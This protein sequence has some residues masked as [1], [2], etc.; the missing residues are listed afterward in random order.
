MGDRFLDYTN[1]K[2]ENDAMRETLKSSLQQRANR[3]YSRDEVGDERG[4]FRLQLSRM[5]RETSQAYGQSDNLVS[6]KQ[7]CDNIRAISDKLS[8]QFGKMLKDQRLR[9]GTSQKALNL[10]LKFLRRLGKAGVPPHCPVDGMVLKA[11]GIS[12]SWTSSD[13]E[14]EYQG[15]IWNLKRTANGKSLAQWEYDI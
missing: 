13:S 9:Y 4:D 5:L 12:G 10:Y 3:V 1:V 14:P 2:S 15:W 6:E 11:A 8:T 7:H